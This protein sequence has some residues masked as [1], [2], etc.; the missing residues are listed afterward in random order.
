MD[1]LLMP[2]VWGENA[3]SPGRRKDKARNQE[4]NCGNNALK[5]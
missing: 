2:C 4:K 5:A 1:S 3:F